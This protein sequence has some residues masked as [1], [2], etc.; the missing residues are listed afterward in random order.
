METGHSTGLL[1]QRR[2]NETNNGNNNNLRGTQQTETQT[3]AQETAQPPHV[4]QPPRRNR[5]MRTSHLYCLVSSVV[6]F[7]AIVTSSGNANNIPSQPSISSQNDNPSI[8]FQKS[9]SKTDLLSNSQGEENTEIS[10]KLVQ[11]IGVAENENQS[12]LDILQNPTPAPGQGILFPYTFFFNEDKKSR[13]TSKANGYDLEFNK[14]PGSQNKNKSNQLPMFL[15]WIDPLGMKFKEL[16]SSNSKDTKDALNHRASR[17]R[18]K[19]FKSIPFFSFILSLVDDAF[20]YPNEGGGTTQ[21]IDKIITSTPRLLAIANLLLA[22]TYLLHSLVADLF[23]GPTDTNATAFGGNVQNQ[24]MNDLNRNLA[25]DDQRH[26][27]S[28]RERLGGFLIFKLLL[29]SAVVEPDTLDLLILLSWYTL[30]SF[31]RSLSYLAA[32]TTNHT[33]QAGLSPRRGVSRLLLLVLCCNFTAAA[34]CVA[35]FHGAGIG[36]V[37]LLTCDC[38]LLALDVFVHLAR[39][40]TQVLEEK[41]S[42]A[43]SVIE[44]RQIQLHAM[45]RD[46]TDVTVLQ[47]NQ[48]QIRYLDQQFEVLEA[49]HSRRL[50]ILEKFVFIIELMNA[51][52]TICHFLHIWSLHG[53]TCGLVDGVLALHLHTAISA[54]SRKVS[55]SSF[56]TS[57]DISFC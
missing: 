47:N 40:V 11:G 28:G 34:C 53:L 51:L 33:S 55:F 14:K 41:H 49:N 31:L 42:Q 44:E 12:M 6:A 45:N 22:V 37:L 21:V 7:L 13:K 46:H 50:Q 1:R 57:H 23:L 4:Y 20:L 36:M 10:P 8:K 24:N 32:C 18:L 27:R 9:R 39:H 48:G 56:L 43:L 54:A 17:D 3:F 16:L 52:L 25:A 19:N 26:R 15:R 29:I 5:P 2:R 38:L 35:L 30:L